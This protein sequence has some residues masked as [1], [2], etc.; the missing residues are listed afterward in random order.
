MKISEDQRGYQDAAREMITWLHEEA[1]RMNDPHAR[2]LLNSAAFAL[3]VRI[4]DEEN[5]RAVEIRG[6]QNSNR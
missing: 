3:G 4:N 5:K 2:R 6:T 1:A